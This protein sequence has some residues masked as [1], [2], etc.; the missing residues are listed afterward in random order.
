MGYFGDILL[1]RQLYVSDLTVED[2]KFLKD[3]MI[4][5]LNSRD[6]S[7]RRI[8][9][10]FFSVQYPIVKMLCFFAIQRGSRRHHG[11]KKWNCLPRMFGY[12]QF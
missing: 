11:A 9:A 1:R 10:G 6:S 5:L 3:G 7:G 8:F 2:I 4:Q 12:K